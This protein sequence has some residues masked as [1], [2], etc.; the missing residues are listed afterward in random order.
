MK[1]IL[2]LFGP[3][4][5]GK[6]NLAIKLAKE[7]NGELI[8]ADSRQVYKNL[9]IGTGKVS[10]DSQVQKHNDYWIVDGIKINGFDL[11]KAGKQF[12]A[13]DFSKFASTSLIR[14]NKAKKLPIIVGGTGFYIKVLT[15]GIESIGIAADQ[16]LRQ[17][18]EKLSKDH[19]YQKLQTVDK[20]RAESMNESDRQNPRRL[21]RAIEICMHQAAKNTKYPLRPRSEA[22]KIPDTEYLIIGLTAPN[23][24]LFDRSDKWLETR[25]NH[26]LIKEVNTLIKDKIDLIW[27]DN[28]GL[29]YRWLSRYLTGKVPKEEA[30]KRLKGD[31]HN[32]IRREK[33]WFNKF[34]NIEIFDITKSDWQKQLEKMIYST[35]GGIKISN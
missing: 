21:I 22:S 26:G 1:K 19:L 8:S 2:V 25:L 20:N 9:D 6:T 17:D 31:A 24:F 4:A 32:R 30:I 3:T 15:D 7:Y 33:T 12:T 16:K 14:I 29:E 13:A 10:F 35:N 11:V 34:Q 28:L 18:L 5:T 27:M 23:Q